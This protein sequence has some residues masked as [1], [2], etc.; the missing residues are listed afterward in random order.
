MFGIDDAVAAVAG[1]GGKLIDRLIPDPTA[2][3]QAK[4]DLM[5]LQQS[6]ELAQMT[7]ETDIV[8][9]QLA[10]NEAEADSSSVFVAGGRP[11]AIWVGVAGLAFSTIVAPLGTWVSTLVGHPTPFPAMDST[12]L[13][14]VLSS[15]LGISGLRT[16]EKV[17]GVKT[18]EP[19]DAVGRSTRVGG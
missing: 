14:M 3:A 15:L 7:A 4:L 10:I 11:A 1:V 18:T 2:A 13:W 12:A 9:A 19:S 16:Y 8:K 17:A 6:G 5:K